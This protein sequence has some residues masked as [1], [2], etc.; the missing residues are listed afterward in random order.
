MLSHTDL[1]KGTLFLINGQPHEVLDY[2]LNFQGRGGSTVTVKVRNITN[3]NTLNKTL[4]PGDQFQEAEVNKKDLRFLY[5][6]RG[7]YYF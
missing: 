5:G 6:N 1:K 3:G 2:A 4:H 7:Q